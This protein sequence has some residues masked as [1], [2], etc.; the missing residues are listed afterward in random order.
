M[1]MYA[2]VSCQ[3]CSMKVKAPFTFTPR[4]ELL[5]MPMP[6]MALLNGAVTSLQTA[7]G[8]TKLLIGARDTAMVNERV[9][10]L[11]SAILDAP[12]DAPAAQSDQFALLE[13]VRSLEKEISDFEA[14]DAEKQRY[15]MKVVWRGTTV[16]SPKEDAGRTEP[17]HWLCATC[18]Q[19]RKKSIL[20]GAGSYVFPGAPETTD[21]PKVE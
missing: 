19:N 20:Q 10:E 12:H 5:S 11:Q 9:S 14:W 13:R 17:H 1:D 8:L 6:D 21:K 15:E 2:L 16:Y 4:R 18:Y 3:T 7:F